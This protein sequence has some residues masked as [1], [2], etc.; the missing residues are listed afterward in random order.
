MIMYLLLQR[1]DIFVSIILN[2]ENAHVLESSDTYEYRSEVHVMDGTIN[3]LGLQHL[4]L[5]Y[6]CY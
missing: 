3:H 2:D 5:T 1:T 6:Y 4:I